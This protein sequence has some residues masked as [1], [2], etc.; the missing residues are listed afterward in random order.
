MNNIVKLISLI[1]NQS[2]KL[3]LC[4]NFQ[5]NPC[6]SKC[7]TR[8]LTE[9]RI[10]KIKSKMFKNILILYILNTYNKNQPS[11]FDENKSKKMT[12]C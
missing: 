12:K 4:S 3:Y 10:L 1:T 8:S 2:I 11:H 9:L 6:T 5:T 7:F